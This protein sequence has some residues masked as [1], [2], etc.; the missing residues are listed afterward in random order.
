MLLEWESKK[1]YTKWM[2]SSDG[3][4]EMVGASLEPMGAQSKHSQALLALCQYA[5]Q[6][7]AYLERIKRHDQMFRDLVEAK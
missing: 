2:G 6:D 3:V 1:F 4:D 7:S 5:L